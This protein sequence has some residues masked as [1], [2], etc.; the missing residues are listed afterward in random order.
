MSCKK[1]YPQKIAARLEAIDSAVDIEDIKLPGY[2]LHELKGDKK[3]IW[4]IKI[5]GNWRIIFRFEDGEAY[6]IDLVDYH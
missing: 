4:S 6:D 5:S 2:N 1:L 3:G